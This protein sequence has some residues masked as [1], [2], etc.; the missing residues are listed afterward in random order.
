MPPSNFEITAPLMMTLRD[1]VSHLRIEL[2]DLRKASE[3]DK[4][5]F[6]AVSTV[7]QDVADTRSRY[8]AY[9]L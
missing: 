8:R 9:V 6:E 5:S 1:E 3:K 4:K 7:K 2:S